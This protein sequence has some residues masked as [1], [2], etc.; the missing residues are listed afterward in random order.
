MRLSEDLITEVACFLVNLNAFSCVCRRIRHILMTR[1]NSHFKE[2]LL[3]NVFDFKR[4]D[5]LFKHTLEPMEPA[6]LT[7][8]RNVPRA[9]SVRVREDELIEHHGSMIESVVDL[10]NSLGDGHVVFADRDGYVQTLIRTSGSKRIQTIHRHQDNSVWTCAA[11][12]L[13]DTP[14]NK[15]LIV[16]SGAADGSLVVS[17]VTLKDFEANIHH[18]ATLEQHHR[19]S[20]FSIT[21]LNQQVFLT[22]S[23]DTEW[24]LYR[25]SG[26]T[27]SSTDF[28]LMHMSGGAHTD[29]IWRIR[30][31]AISQEGS[32]GFGGSN[33]VATFGWDG[34]T[35]IWDLQGGELLRSHT[36][37]TRILDGAV[38][39]Q[40]LYSWI[41]TRNISFLDVRTAAPV[42]WV[43]TLRT[44]GT[45][46][47]RMCSL[48]S[49]NDSYTVAVGCD[50]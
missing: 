23:W 5:L 30:S 15:R 27:N 48:Q 35:G 33:T 14:L 3:T 36:G 37:P 49:H 24:G 28:R 38:L 39:G 7:Y 21:F 9:N 46:L 26:S 45:E 31:D 8:V 20:V 40:G 44:A 4:F 19:D 22:S 16:A 18:T 2:I 29:A 13:H 32:E 50:N 1:M 6:F 11:S 12:A 10:R 47:S 43:P 17:D 41:G 25:R 34:V 42:S